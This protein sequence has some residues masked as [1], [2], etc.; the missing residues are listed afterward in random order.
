MSL[1]YDADIDMQE[2]I[3]EPPCRIGQASWTV[4]GLGLPAQIGKR[5]KLV[6]IANELYKLK[7]ADLLAWRH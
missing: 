3:R 2:R 6:C 7:I 4:K 5:K 1:S